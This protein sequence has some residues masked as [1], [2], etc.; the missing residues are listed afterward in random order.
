MGA[1][2]FGVSEIIRRP[3]DCWFKLLSREEGEFYSI[4]CFDAKMNTLFNM[5]RA[6]YENPN[7]TDP[8]KDD[9]RVQSKQDTLRITDFRFLRVLG[10]GSFGRVSDAR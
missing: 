1:L 3:V 8:S 2:S 7:D 5:N 4:P 9:N 6:K 10:K